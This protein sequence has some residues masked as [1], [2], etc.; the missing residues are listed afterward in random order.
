MPN[1]PNGVVFPGYRGRWK[2]RETIDDVPVRRTWLYPS[3][4]R[5]S[6]KRIAGYASFTMT[7]LV[8]T[9][10]GPKPDRLFVESQ[11]LT[12]GVV[13]ILMRRL[14]GVPYVYN[15]PDLQLDVAKQAGF[16]SNRTLL[17][18]MKEL[19]DLALRES[20]TVSTVTE[21]FIEHFEARGVPRDRISFLPNGADSEFLRPM[22]PDRELI[23]R[24]RLQG[25]KVFTYIGTHA[26]YHGLETLVEAAERLRQRDDIAFLIIGEGPERERV[27]GLARGYGLTNIVFTTSPY[28]ELARCYSIT[29]AAL[30]VIRD[31]E[32]AR[33]MR[34]AKIFPALSC[35]V[36]VVFSGAG[37]TPELLERHGVGVAVAAESPEALADAI[38]ELADDPERRA[39]FGRAGRALVEERYSWSS[40]VDE[41]LAEVGYVEG[42]V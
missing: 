32:V 24:W 34:P 40:I 11:P 22:E 38:A 23:E 15:V 1:Y 18:M 6:I 10:L 26:Y 39:A 27:E 20:W 31:L 14:R 36:P 30:A 9:L 2:L 17:R 4:G 21:G 29:W 8:A 33:K 5:S 28:E 35:G 19:E 13:A 42:V 12:L 25:K 37:E 41:W 16:L 3:A 7:A